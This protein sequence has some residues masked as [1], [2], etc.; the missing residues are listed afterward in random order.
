MTACSNPE[1]YSLKAQ[2]LPHAVAVAA[3]ARVP[4]SARPWRSSVAHLVVVPLLVPV[5]PRLVPAHH[6]A[7]SLVEFPEEFLWRSRGVLAEVEAVPLHS[8]PNNLKP[9]QATQCRSRCKPGIN[10]PSWSLSAVLYAPPAF[11]PGPGTVQQ[12]FGLAF[13]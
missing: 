8:L 7:E 10:V 1:G 3:R 4:S 5:V 12:P 2:R 11:Q 13:Q 9:G 6:G